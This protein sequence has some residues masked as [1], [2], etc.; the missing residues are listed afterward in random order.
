M[1]H[2]SHGS[3]GGVDDGVGGYW[4]F[5]NCIVVVVVYTDES[6][7]INFRSSIVCK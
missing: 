3:T 4:F 5:N 2:S 1:K 7:V 6:K